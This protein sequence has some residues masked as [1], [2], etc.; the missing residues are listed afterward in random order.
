MLI[1]FIR[2][3]FVLASSGVSYHVAR[4][5]QWD[6]FRGLVVGLVVAMGIIVVEMGF[7]RT[8]ISSI[9]SIV[10]GILI[11]LLFATLFYHAILLAFG[12]RAN[13]LLGTQL[14][15]DPRNPENSVRIPLI[16]LDEFKQILE[17][18]L[19]CIFCYLGIA[20][21]YQTRDSFNFIIPYVEFK[22]H[23]KGVRPVILDTS[24]VIDGRIADICETKIIDGPL[25]VPR[26][27]LQELQK[28]ADSP[29][30]LRRNR[31]RR[32]LDMLNR[33]QRM[34]SVQIQLRDAPSGSGPVDNRLVQMAK[35]LDARVVTNDFNLNKIAQLQGVDVIN[36]NDLANAL[37]PVALPGED[38]TIRLI[39][40]GE[41]AGQGVGYLDDGTMVVAEE[42][43]DRIGQTVAITVTSV[44]QTSAGRMIFGKIKE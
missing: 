36:V 4:V 25:I 13:L 11:G 40:P 22:K 24:V 38:I 5:A 19:V 2:T 37:K 28:I 15:P 44:L 29:D 12:E 17:L 27:V 16:G 26:F 41:E 18:G 7:S 43:K 8:P 20:V 31:G 21:L 33:L 39:R 1:W 14:V 10:F 32:G 23:E 35:A 6:V 42:G 34:E 3:I 30:R 9:S